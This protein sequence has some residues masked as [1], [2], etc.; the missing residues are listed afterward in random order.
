[1]S[2]IAGLLA[3]S[4]CQV[5]GVTMIDGGWGTVETYGFIMLL[6]VIALILL[7]VFGVGFVLFL[8][9]YLIKRTEGFK[10]LF[11]ISIIGGILAF[12]ILI[13]SGIFI[14]F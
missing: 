3:L 1:V 5:D 14:V 10:R 12:I 11:I 7:G 4:G 13:A 2:V 9:L 8:V 6:P